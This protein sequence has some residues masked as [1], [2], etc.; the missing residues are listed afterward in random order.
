[1]EKYFKFDGSAT[2]SEYW[3]VNI[4]AGITVFV[5]ILVGSVIAS[6]GSTIGIAFGVSIIVVAFV[7]AF[8]LSVAAAVRRCRD[9]D[10]NPWWAAAM[11]IPYI[12]W[13][14]TIVLGCLKTD[15]GTK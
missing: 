14:V 1:M 8:W 13:I 3:G 5:L 10:I 11:V 12:G 2:R 4:L 9:A 7:A 15:E 6:T